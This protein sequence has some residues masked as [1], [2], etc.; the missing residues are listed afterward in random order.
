[1]VPAC[2]VAGELPVGAGIVGFGSPA[3][4]EEVLGLF[5]VDNA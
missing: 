4:K 3:W 1:M 5:V 2:V